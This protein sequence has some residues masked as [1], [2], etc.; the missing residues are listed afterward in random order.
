MKKFDLNIEQI[1]ENWEPHHAVRE[2]IANAFDEQKLTKTS[3]IKIFKDNENQWHIRDYGRGINIEHFTQNEN[4]EKL[5]TEGI[6]GKFGIGL[7]DALATFYRHDINVKI[8]SKNG[9]FTIA[10]SAKMGFE[11]VVTL[12]MYVNQIQSSSFIGTEFILSNIKDNDIQKAKDLFH[13]FAGE[14]VIETCSQGVILEK[15]DIG[16]I[17]INGILIAEEENFLFSYNITNV[18]VAIRKALNRER[19]NVGRTAYSNSIKSILLKC[20]S[21]EIAIALVNDFKNYSYGIIHDE[22]KWIDIQEHAVKIL[23]HYE[24]VVFVTTNETILHPGLIDEVQTCGYEIVNIP[25]NLKEKIQGQS[26]VDGNVIREF[27]QFR[28]E[29]N[30]NF[31]F[32]F[33]P[34]DDLNEIEKQNY[35]LIDK[36]LSLV[37]ADPK[38]INK[39]LISDKMQKDDSSYMSVDGLYQNNQIIIK[40]SV[41]NDTKKF[42]AVLL[43]EFAH[44]K[45]GFPD[46]TR[47]FEIELTNMLG[48]IGLKALG[49]IYENNNC[50]KKKTRTIHNPDQIEMEL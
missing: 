23:N 1:L 22:L 3:A 42:I 15:N 28:I 8:I 43:H 31:E 19:T 50:Q 47:E 45:S 46:A 14:K 24:N 6:I 13:I 41:L 40:R 18:S 38:K 7:K 39:I 16:K 27:D 10:K 37:E 34:I 49:K 36:I 21:H 35:Y 33:I 26:D 4:E 48:I 9:G 30:D 29:R 32:E 2:V 5:N 25:S 11:S 12:H 17:Y 20:K 44:A